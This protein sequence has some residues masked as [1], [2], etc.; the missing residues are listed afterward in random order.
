MKYRIKVTIYGNGD[1]AYIPQW[2]GWMIWHN[3]WIRKAVY[4]DEMVS[5]NLEHQARSY[6]SEILDRDRKL[7]IINKYYKPYP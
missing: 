2:K 7:K 5:F 3:F 6:L 1:V 4:W